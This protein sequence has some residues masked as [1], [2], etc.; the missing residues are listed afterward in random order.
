[1]ATTP[2]KTA[3]VKPTEETLSVD[4]LFEAPVED[5]ADETPEQ[6]KIREL[7]AALVAEEELAR[8]NPTRAGKPLPENELT[9]EQ[10]RIRDLEDR[11]AQRKA[12]RDPE[13]E[14]V[15]AEDG[16]HFHIVKDGFTAFGQ[17]W[18][19]GQEL[20]VDPAGRVAASTKNRLGHSWL[21]TIDDP[22]AQTEL[23]GDVYLRRGPFRGRKGEVFDDEI[24][25][26]D[27]RRGLAVPITTED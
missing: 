19:R 16:I 10:R 3:P 23:F 17:A 6:K 18:F 25:R 27:K 1:M 4:D 24:S 14:F 7:E 12:S 9:D 22:G 11:L 5:T 2:R 21:D 20:L 15:S 8:T 13:S 26:L